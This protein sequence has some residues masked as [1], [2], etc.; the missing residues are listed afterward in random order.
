MLDL[1]QN[2]IYYLYYGYDK[3]YFD[4]IHQMFPLMALL[5]IAYGLMLIAL[6]VSQI[7]VRFQLA[8]FREGAPE[9]LLYLYVA[10]LVTP[11]AYLLLATL[12]TGVSLIQPT[13]AANL[14]GYFI[15]I[16]IMFLINK[17]Y[18]NNRR[19]LFVN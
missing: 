13:I 7:Y 14:L 16:V 19:E 6:A 1:Q 11:L 4:Q 18:Y 9:K 5:D 12:A 2:E 17:V 15:T 8:G 10:Y 3:H